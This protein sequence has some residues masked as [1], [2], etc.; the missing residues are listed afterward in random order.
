MSIPQVPRSWRFYTP[1]NAPREDNTIDLH[2]A[3][4][5][6]GSV[7]GPFVR[8]VAP[9]RR[10]PHR[11][12]GRHRPAARPR[13]RRRPPPRRRQ[14]RHRAL[15]RPARRHPALARAR[16]ARGARCTSCTASASRGTCTPA[17]GSTRS[18]ARTGSPT[19]R[20]SPTTPPT[21]VG[22][23][24]SGPSPPSWPFDGRYHAMVCGSPA[25]GG[26]QQGHARGAPQ[27]PRDHPVRGVRGRARHGRRQHV[28][29]V[30]SPRRFVMSDTQHDEAVHVDAEATAE[31][32]RRESR[33]LAYQEVSLRA[34]ELLAS[35]QRAADEAVAEAQSY[36]RDLEETAREQY[37]HI[38]QRAHD[39]ARAAGGEPAADEPSRPAPRRSRTPAS[40][41]DGRA[42]RVRAHLRPGGPHPAQGGARGAHRRARP[43]RRPRGRHLALGGRRARRSRPP[44]SARSRTARGRRARP[45][46]HGAARLPRRTDAHG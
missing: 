9:R 35:A 44:T 21:R 25:H 23:G 24:S 11:C 18:P 14:H 40:G 5:A 27:A 17:S 16:A 8:K 22:G 29:A 10:H 7:S 33:E 13:R 1:A 42:A 34:V 12:P 28:G 15:P 20:W 31:R 26:P 6:G 30:S 46:T 19:R 3:V 41:L 4:L 45:G 43:A 2:V 37:R 38:L 32:D 39:A 36:A